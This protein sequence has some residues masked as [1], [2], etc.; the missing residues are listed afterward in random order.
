[1]V[2]LLPTWHQIPGAPDHIQT[3]DL[4]LPLLCW[5]TSVTAYSSLLTRHIL[6]LLRRP[7]A[8]LSNNTLLQTSKAAQLACHLIISISDHPP[9]TLLSLSLFILDAHLCPLAG[10]YPH[11]QLQQTGKPVVT[12]VWHVWLRCSVN[13]TKPLYTLGANQNQNIDVVLALHYY[14]CL[15]ALCT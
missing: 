10:T 9:F 12:L 5:L 7:P 14:H 11:P 3:S 2:A 4:L 15:P 13:L 6:Y 8:R 1:M